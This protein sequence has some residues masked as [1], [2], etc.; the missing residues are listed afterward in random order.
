MI[1][2]ESE[3]RLLISLLVI[4]TCFDEGIPRE[5]LDADNYHLYFYALAVKAKGNK[6]KSNELFEYLA[7]YNFAGWANSI[8]RSLAQSQLKA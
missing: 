8:I 2:L 1:E 5:L 6:E 4:N 3:D 7:N